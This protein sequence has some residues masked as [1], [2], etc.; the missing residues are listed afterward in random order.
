MP[1]MFITYTKSW[2]FLHSAQSSILSS[3]VSLFVSVS[4]D[5]SE[6]GLGRLHF[7]AKKSNWIIFTCSVI[8][9]SVF[10]SEFDCI[11]IRNQCSSNNSLIKGIDLSLW[12]VGFGLLSS[13]S[14][15]TQLLSISC[16]PLSCLMA[17]SLLHFFFWP[18]YCVETLLSQSDIWC[19]L[20]ELFKFL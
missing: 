20:L 12:E 4:F 13:S 19:R 10:H 2:I 16:I 17:Y 3:A 5:K 11:K 1:S 9:Y 15:S 7:K 14:S 8:G 6:M 18:L